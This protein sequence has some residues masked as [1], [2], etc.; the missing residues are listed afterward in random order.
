PPRSRTRAM[1]S[2]R[3]RARREHQD[4]TVSAR[5]G[6]EQTVEDGTLALAPDQ[7]RLWEPNRRRPFAQH[8]STV[9]REART[10]ARTLEGLRRS[11]IRAPTSP[12]RLSSLAWASRRRR[13]ERRTR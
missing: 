5:R 2:C 12:A 10:V 3:R 11:G 6:L 9:A 13:R 1:R 8:R 4:A 7:V